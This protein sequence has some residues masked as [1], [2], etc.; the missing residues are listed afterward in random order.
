[1]TVD[2]PEDLVGL[3]HIGRIVALA[4]QEMREAVK[5]GVTT[6]ELDVIGG[7]VLKRNGA[8]SAPQLVYNFP[9]ATCISINDEAA[10]GIP[11][12]RVIQ[13]GDLVNLD[14][15]AEL[16]GYF[17]DAGWT[18]A[19][20]PVD[21]IRHNLLLCAQRALKKTLAVAKAGQPINLIGKVIEEEAKSC[22][23]KTLHD[24]GGHGVGRGI[25]E[26]PHSISCFYNPGDKRI[27]QEGSVIA[28]EPFITT[29]A[30]FVR[31]MPDHWTLKTSDNTLSAQFEHTIVIT[32]NKPVIITAL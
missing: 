7:N 15:S 28:I 30:Q 18:A 2:S 21:A 25:H 13:P 27:L 4:L 32:R 19:V 5:P 1:M 14:V 26:E 6:G 17:A 29:G 22:G 23:F 20:E 16:D 24:L 10:H 9:G 31:T 3:K 12:S 11:G 8:R